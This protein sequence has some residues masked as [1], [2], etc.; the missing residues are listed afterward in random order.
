MSPASCL[1]PIKRPRM[2]LK[3]HGG[4]GFVRLAIAISAP[5]GNAGTD[6]MC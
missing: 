2:Y 4:M 1:L 6:N 3:V 5:H